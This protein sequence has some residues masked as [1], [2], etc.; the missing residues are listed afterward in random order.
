MHNMSLQS[1]I[2]GNVQFNQDFEN[3]KR[4]FDYKERISL[5]FNV[6]VNRDQR[7]HRVSPAQSSKSAEDVRHK[8]WLVL[9]KSVNLTTRLMTIFLISTALRLGKVYS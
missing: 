2:T 7:R 1:I 4:E 9:A 3:F 8:W 6:S 5:M